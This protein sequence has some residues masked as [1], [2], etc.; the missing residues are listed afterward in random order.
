MILPCIR[1]ACDLIIFAFPCLSHTMSIGLCPPSHK[2]TIHKS[3]S[4]STRVGQEPFLFFKR[5][6][7][8]WATG[9]SWSSSSRLLLNFSIRASPPSRNSSNWPDR[10]SVVNLLRTLVGRAPNRSVIA[11]KRSVIQSARHMSPSLSHPFVNS[12]RNSSI[13]KTLPAR[14]CA[15]RADSRK[16]FASQLQTGSQL[17]WPCNLFSFIS[18]VNIVHPMS[19]F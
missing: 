18:L 2:Q 19:D 6:Y 13:V 11:Q 9:R 14:L 8:A 3:K 15:P 5:L 10:G 16:S 1:S 7:E 17:S 4:S 12:L